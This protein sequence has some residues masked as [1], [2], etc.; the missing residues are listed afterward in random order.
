MRNTH[1]PQCEGEGSITEDL[2]ELD[3]GGTSTYTCFM[4]TGTGRYESS[5]LLM[6]H[7]RTKLLNL[8]DENERL[9][10]EAQYHKRMS[11]DAKDREEM[12]RAE[13]KGM[14]VVKLA[15]RVGELEEAM[16][17]I[18]ATTESAVPS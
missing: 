2:D 18:R 17:E 9:V 1:C 5:Y 8:G 6:Q 14:D 16:Y 3:G 11:R 12:L 13:I 10:L 15:R 4:C 7:L